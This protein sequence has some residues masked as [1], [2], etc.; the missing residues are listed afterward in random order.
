MLF[1]LF[2]FD[3]NTNNNVASANSF[4]CHQL[5]GAVQACT[6]SNSKVNIQNEVSHISTLYLQL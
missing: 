2:T 4:T 6:S 1:N 5:Q 3:I